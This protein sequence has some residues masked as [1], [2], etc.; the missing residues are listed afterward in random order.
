MRWGEVDMKN[1]AYPAGC[2]KA[3]H[4]R[5]FADED[6]RPCDQCDGTGHKLVGDVYDGERPCPDCQGTGRELPADDVQ[7]ARL[8]ATG[9]EVK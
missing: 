6:R 7:G 4:D 3:T 9:A 5:A 8:R 1:T 2:T